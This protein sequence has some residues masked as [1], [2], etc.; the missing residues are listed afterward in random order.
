MYKAIQGGG[1]DKDG[2]WD[3]GRWA[4]T[5]ESLCVVSPD[6]LQEETL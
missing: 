4:L 1:K 6:A 3:L 5:I 2:P